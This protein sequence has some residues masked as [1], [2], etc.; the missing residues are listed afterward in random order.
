MAW[1]KEE[2]INFCSKCGV[3]PNKALKEGHISLRGPM[4]TGATIASIKSRQVRKRDAIKAV[5]KVQ[6]SL[7]EPDKTMALEQEV[8]G[9]DEGME[10]LAVGAR[11]S[12]VGYR[13]RP[14]D[15]DN[16]TAGCK[17]LI[18]GIVRSRLIKGDDWESLQ[19]QCSQ[20]KVSNLSREGTEI[21]IETF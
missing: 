13:V 11:V 12:I 4:L 8:C 16:F 7:R 6:D 9:Q 5:S 15:P 14:I 17:G 10:P 3:D 18:D 1:S 20:K 21:L 2:F 19:I